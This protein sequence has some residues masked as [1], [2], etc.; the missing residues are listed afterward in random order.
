MR[1]LIGNKL[2]PSA[3]HLVVARLTTM[4][5]GFGTTKS[6]GIK[7]TELSEKQLVELRIDPIRLWNEL[8]KTCEW[9]KGERWGE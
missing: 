9:G 4:F 2:I 3:R 7:T 8:H 5:R 1:S 6:W